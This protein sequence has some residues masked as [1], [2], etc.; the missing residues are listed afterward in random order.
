MPLDPPALDP[1]ALDHARLADALL[2][3]VL[4]AGRVEMAHYTAGFTVETKADSSPVTIADR[5]AEAVLLAGLASA[6]PDTPVI[7][8]EA[9]AEG[10]IPAAADML[11]LVDPLDGTREFINRNGEF[12]V[13]VALVAAGRPVFGIV[14]APAIGDLYATIG[15]DRAVNCTVPAGTRATRLADLAPRPIHTRRP[16]PRALVAVASRSHMT[17][18]G[19]AWLARWPIAE[20]RNAGSSLKFCLV[21]KGEA[22]VYPRHGPTNEWDTAA[23]DAVLRAAGGMVTT[24]DGRPFPYGKHAERYRNGNYIAW[25]TPT[26]LAE[27]AA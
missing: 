8:E 6:A 23:G 22:D 7:A 1:L 25:G 15:P 18:E 5:E 13:N 19:E 2:A 12:T 26:A 20:R 17:A 27:P 24:L 10:R 4:E 21:A 9:F 3:A 16:D 14:Y 11:F